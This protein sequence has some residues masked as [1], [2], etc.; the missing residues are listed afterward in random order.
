MV[1]TIR[2]RPN[3]APKEAVSFP[4]FD[5]CDLV[6]QRWEDSD[7]RDQLS[8]RFFFVVYQ[9]DRAGVPV[10]VNTRFWTMPTEDLET[11][12]RDCFERTVTLIKEDK[13]D[14]LPG[15][16]DNVACHV[17]PHGRDSRD[18]VPT[19]NGGFAVRKSFWLNQS[20]LGEQLA[21]GEDS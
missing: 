13:A 4:A 10:L 17:R 7:L 3:G 14:Y 1:R 9:L 11:Y 15:S 8:R 21:S 19:P 18:I 12:A 2:L 5:Y 20:Y 16:L 6:K